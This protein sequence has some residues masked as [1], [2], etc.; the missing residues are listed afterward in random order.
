MNGLENIQDRTYL[1]SFMVSIGRTGVCQVA[2]KV[3]NI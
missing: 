3:V 2:I 1:L